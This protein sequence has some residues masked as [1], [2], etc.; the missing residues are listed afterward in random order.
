VRIFSSISINC[1][2]KKVVQPFAGQLFVDPLEF[3]VNFHQ[4][5]FG[6]FLGQ[7]EL[8]GLWHR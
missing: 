1:Q 6:F 5:R 4:D 3:F 8:R 2:I 7:A